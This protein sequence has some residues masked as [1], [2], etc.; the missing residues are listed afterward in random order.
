[1]YCPDCGQQNSDEARFCSACGSPIQ[2]AEDKAPAPTPPVA[3]PSITT[4]YAGFW[5]RLEASVYDGVYIFL[6]GIL[7]AIFLVLLLSLL[8]FFLDFPDSLIGW[9][10]LILWL[11]FP[12]VYYVLYTGFD[13]QTPGKRW[14]GIRVVNSNNQVP[15]MWAALRREI[16]GKIISALPLL[17]GFIWVASDP[18]KRG[19]HDRIGGTYVIKVRR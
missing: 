16:P 19:W 9:A 2:Q 14:K 4:E 5:I 8:N 12:W 10:L 11:S 18:G 17:L 15:G 13:G 3:S 7:L 6:A 1:M